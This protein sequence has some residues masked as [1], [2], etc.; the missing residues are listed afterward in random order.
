MPIEVIV[1]PFVVASRTQKIPASLG[2]Q[3]VDV[4]LKRGRSLILSLSSKR[5]LFGMVTLPTSSWVVHGGFGYAWRSSILFTLTSPPRTPW[6]SLNLNFVC[7]PGY[8]GFVGS[9]N[10]LCAAS[11]GTRPGS[12]P[13]R[14]EASGQHGG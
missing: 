4:H 12:W 13:V 3:Q 1:P 7:N 14:R 10:R 2:A 11:P 8:R 5:K 6:P 9:T